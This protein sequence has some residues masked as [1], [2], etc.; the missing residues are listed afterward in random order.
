[1]SSAKELGAH[2]IPFGPH[3]V[4]EALGSARRLAGSLARRVRGTGDSVVGA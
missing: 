2:Q 1:M 4:E 3:A